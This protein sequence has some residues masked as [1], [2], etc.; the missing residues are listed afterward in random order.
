MLKYNCFVQ[1]K[2]IDAHTCWQCFRQKMHLEYRSKVECQNE[3]AEKVEG[4]T[5]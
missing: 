2:E 1:Q 3:N 4:E 5:F